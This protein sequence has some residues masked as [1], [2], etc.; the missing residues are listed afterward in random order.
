MRPELNGTREWGVGAVTGYGRGG[1]TKKKERVAR[2]AIRF[3]SHRN[4]FSRLDSD[5][6]ERARQTPRIA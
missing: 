2:S 1:E 5:R 3:G 6:M 4:S